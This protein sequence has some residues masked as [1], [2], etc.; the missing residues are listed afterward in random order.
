MRVFL[1]GK[2][3]LSGVNIPILIQRGVLQ[4]KEISEME[5]SKWSSSTRITGLVGY[6]VFIKVR[7][8]GRVCLRLVHPGTSTA[9]HCCRSSKKHVA[10]WKREQSSFPLAPESTLIIAF[11]SLQM[12]TLL[13]IS[14]DDAKMMLR[15]QVCA[16][17]ISR[18][19]LQ[20]INTTHQF[21]L[22]A[23][24]AVTW[25]SFTGGDVPVLSQ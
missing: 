14:V 18:D 15:L 23:S 19:W 4:D 6:L 1:G 9:F 5:I 13:L 8:C 11:S 20:Q 16:L 22:P 7:S 2:C 3:N 25:L 24:S 10:P 12:Y 17:W 21:Q